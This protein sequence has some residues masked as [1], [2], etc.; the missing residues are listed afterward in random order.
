MPCGTQ[1]ITTER[2]SEDLACSLIPKN[3]CVEDGHIR[4]IT[5]VL[6][7]T[8]ACCTA[9]A[10]S[11]ARATRMTLSALWCRNCCRPSRS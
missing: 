1:V 5:T 6:P 3:D 10:W 9:A 8:T 7:P 11:T 4:L 2:L